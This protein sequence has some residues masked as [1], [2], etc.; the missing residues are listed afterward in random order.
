MYVLLQFLLTYAR[1]YY[2]IL[3]KSTMF[4]ATNKKI[5]K[6]LYAESK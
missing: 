1:Y 5:K 3:I 6:K 4:L 2:Q